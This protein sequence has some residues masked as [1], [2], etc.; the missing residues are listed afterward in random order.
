MK[1]TKITYTKLSSGK[2]KVLSIENAAT[3]RE[4]DKEF[5]NCVAREYI[6]GFPRYICLAGNV[7][8]RSHATSYYLVES[9]IYSSKDFDYIIKIMKSAGARLASI[10]KAMPQEPKTKEIII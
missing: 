9:R 3:P 4:L 7:S 6:D 8:A 1:R 10:K 5:G 2:I